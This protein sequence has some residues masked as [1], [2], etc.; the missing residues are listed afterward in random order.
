MAIAASL[1]P[2]VS[3]W[4]IPTLFFLGW[5]NLGALCAKV[6]DANK[7]TAIMWLLI[8]LTEVSYDAKIA[9]PYLNMDLY[10]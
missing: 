2:L 6:K 4:Y 3:F 8:A 9:L 5:T 10:G 1:T 7:K